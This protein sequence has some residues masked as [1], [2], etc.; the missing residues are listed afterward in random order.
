M[1]NRVSGTGT[2]Y[3]TR[4]F[5]AMHAIHP[6]EYAPGNNVSITFCFDALVPGDL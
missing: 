4:Q 3:P 1:K 5:P 6:R 2:L